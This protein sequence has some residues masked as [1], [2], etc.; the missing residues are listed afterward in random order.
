M[1]TRLRAMLGRS[2]APS[3]WPEI[4]ASARQHLANVAKVRATREFSGDPVI[5]REYLKAE[6]IVAETAARSKS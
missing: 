3:R 2:Q 4:H 6:R 5:E 1:L